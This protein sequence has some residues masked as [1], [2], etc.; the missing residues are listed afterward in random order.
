MHHAVH[1]K[2]TLIPKGH[3]YFLTLLDMFAATDR[4]SSKRFA[5]TGSLLE[6]ILQNQTQYNLKITS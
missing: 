3:I 5:P 6:S 4:K 2:P 1:F